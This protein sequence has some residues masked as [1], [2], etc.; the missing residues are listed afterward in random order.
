MW[1]GE[2]EESSLE[3]DARGICRAEDEH[4]RPEVHGGAVRA[5]RAP[6]Q[7]VHDHDPVVEL[8]DGIQPRAAVLEAR[9]IRQEVLQ[10]VVPGLHRTR[11]SST[12]F[13]S[14]L[15]QAQLWSNATIEIGIRTLHS[16]RRM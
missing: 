8:R 11:S 9:R 16:R 14:S 5:H 7:G 1:L 4:G 12:I 6:A 3:C 13:F 10:P 2:C 15:K